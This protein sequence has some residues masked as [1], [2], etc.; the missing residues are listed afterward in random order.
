M[1]NIKCYQFYKNL[2]INGFFWQV[3]WYAT[4]FFPLGLTHSCPN[5]KDFC[6]LLF[7]NEYLSARDAS[8]K[9]T[10]S[11]QGQPTS[12]N[13]VDGG[14]QKSNL[15]ATNLSISE[16]LEPQSSTWPLLILHHYSASHSA[17]IH[18]PY[19]PSGIVTVCKWLSWSLFLG[20]NDL[21]NLVLG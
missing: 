10:Y 1:E 2:S 13:N 12:N 7:T 16:G 21:W 6:L 18:F 15:L 19:S 8:V 9:L 11:L 14:V 3:L 4:Q 5:C 17:H 20:E